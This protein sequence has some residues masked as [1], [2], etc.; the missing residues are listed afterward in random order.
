MS[1]FVVSW[2]P[3]LRRVIRIEHGMTVL[4]AGDWDSDYGGA[5]YSCV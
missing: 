3:V 1:S 5:G 2:P 4:I